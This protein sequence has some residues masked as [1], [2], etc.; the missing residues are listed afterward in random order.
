MKLPSNETKTPK[1]LLPHQV[2][3]VETFFNPAS[4]RVL[5]LRWEVGLG[6]HVALLALSKRLLKNRPT[7]R[8]LFLGPKALQFQNVDMF[9]REGIKNQFVDRLS[10]RELLDSTYEV[11]FWP[12]GIVTTMSMDFAKQPDIMKSLTA[13]HWDLV[14]ANEA[15]MFGGA[16]LELLRTVCA[17]AQRIILD[18]IPDLKLPDIFASDEIEVI[19]KLRDQVIGHDGLLL[20]KVAR[21]VLHEIP[22]GL[23]SA[24]LNLI[25]TMKDMR[26]ILD[27]ETRNQSLITEYFSNALGSSPAAL[28]QVLQLF[29]VGLGGKKRLNILLE[30]MEGDPLKDGL[31]AQLISTIVEK[32]AEVAKRV[33]TNIEAITDDSKLNAFSELLKNI[34]EGET[35]SKRICVLTGY[36]QTLYY[37]SSEIEY[38]G[39]P[40]SVLQGSM[41]G[42]ERQRCMEL[43][44]SGGDILIATKVIIQDYDLSGV[45]DLVLYDLSGSKVALQKLLGR[46]DRFGRQSQLNIH[47]LVPTKAL[48][49]ISIQSIELLRETLRF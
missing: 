45:T 30:A 22:F 44:L 46:F 34:K 5:L 47:V 12:A 10:F 40:F 1:P 39:L 42:E 27:S 43:F 31:D 41:S 15:H 36:G 26:Q 29:A 20:D 16:R 3:L 9:S 37:L 28:E 19:E 7:A 49:D 21:P 32:T 25:E 2:T 17:S 14:V 13:A 11:D 4:K 23:T 24:E 8:I 33:L 6:R 48:D 18:T 38:R 35:L